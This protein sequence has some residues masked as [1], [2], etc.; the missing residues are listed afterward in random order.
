MTPMS[1]YIQVPLKIPVYTPLKT[2][3]WKD[4]HELVVDPI[5][6]QIHK[7]KNN[8]NYARN[9]VDDIE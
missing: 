9:V 5:V 8:I 4:A 2:R 3:T 1:N 7:E 6:Q